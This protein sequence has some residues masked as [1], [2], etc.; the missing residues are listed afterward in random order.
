MPIFKNIFHN[1][2]LSYL[3][4]VFAALLVV[5]V[6]G[7][8][9]S[10]E[11][12]LFITVGL[13]CMSFFS[14]FIV[15]VINDIGSRKDDKKIFYMEKGNREPIKIAEEEIDNMSFPQ[16]D[17]MLKKVLKQSVKFRNNAYFTIYNLRDSYAKLVNS[18]KNDLEQIEKINQTYIQYFKNIKNLVVVKEMKNGVLILKIKDK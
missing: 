18:K 6:Y 8:L 12:A 15:A 16:N 14:T 17:R 3:Q 13:S 11:V 4:I 9:L 10:V 1:T 7:K 5:F 2:N